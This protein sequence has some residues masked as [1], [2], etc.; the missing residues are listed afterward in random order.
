M[1]I[2]EIPEVK[3]SDNFTLKELISSASHPELVI[4]P[5]PSILDK[6]KFFCVNILEPYRK[7][8]GLNK[9]VRINS[10]WR[11]RTL[12]T[13]IGG[14]K[15]SRHL[16]YDGLRYLGVAADT[17]PT[18]DT[19]FAAFSRSLFM[20]RELVRTFILY[21]DRNFIHVDCNIDRPSVVWMVKF[22]DDDVYHHLTEGEVSD[23]AETLKDKFNFEV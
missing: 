20:P 5:P 11:N 23:I 14:E 8:V 16:I 21:P 6:L 7:I 15:M 17:A 22:R 1:M 13:A 19:I 12:N 9:P 3:L 2:Q 18:A 10:G 4:V